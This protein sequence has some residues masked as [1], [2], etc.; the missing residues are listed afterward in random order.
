MDVNSQHH[1]QEVHSGL[2]IFKMAANIKIQKI[3]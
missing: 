1:N 2:G 3:V